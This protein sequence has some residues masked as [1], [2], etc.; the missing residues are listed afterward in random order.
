MDVM[1]FMSATGSSGYVRVL[2]HVSSTVL[3]KD[4]RTTL[5]LLRENDEVVVTHYNE[6]ECVLMSPSRYEDLVA[7]A[8]VSDDVKST[9]QVLFAAATTGVA[10]PSETLDRL[11]PGHGTHD[12][13]AVAEFAA[14]FPITLSTAEDGAPNTRGR[15]TAVATN[16][17]EFGTDDELNLA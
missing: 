8:A 5:D 9:M 2:K 3:H 15:L 6:V 17:E 11:L 1:G 14:R 12:W 4:T 16:L 13:R 7:R 10:I